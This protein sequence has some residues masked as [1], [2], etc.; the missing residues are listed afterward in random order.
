M[1]GMHRNATHDPQIPLDAKTQVQR[2][3]SQRVLA[4]LKPNRIICKRTDANCSSF[5]LAVIKC[6]YLPPTYLH[7]IED[8]EDRLLLLM[9]S[10]S[11]V[12]TPF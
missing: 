12:D 2:T 4:V 8:I 10:T 9:S 7:F 6:I 1:T 3:L 5:L 11:F